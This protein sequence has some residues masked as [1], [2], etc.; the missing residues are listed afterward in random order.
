M[1][2][3]AVHLFDICVLSVLPSNHDET[4]LILIAHTS[5]SVP[6]FGRALK[7]TNLHVER[8]FQFVASPVFGAII[9]FAK[10][11]VPVAAPYIQ[12]GVLLTDNQTGSG[13]S[14]AS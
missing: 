7:R 12:L 8:D 6:C 5:G 3:I 14:G 2:T 10:C 11:A 13:N 1:L 9:L 4:T